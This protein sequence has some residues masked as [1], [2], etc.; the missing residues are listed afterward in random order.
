M[1][2]T[3]E[4]NKFEIEISHAYA[5]YAHSTLLL[6]SLIFHERIRIHERVARV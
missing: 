6:I 5:D 1:N 3:C 4:I 2:V